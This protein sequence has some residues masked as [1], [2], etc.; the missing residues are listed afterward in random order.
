[1]PVLATIKIKN[2]TSNQFDNLIARLK[3]DGW[4]VTAKNMNEIILTKEEAD[5]SVSSSQELCRAT[6]NYFQKRVRPRTDQIFPFEHSSQ[7]LNKCTVYYGND[8]I[9][10]SIELYNLLPP[11]N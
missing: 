9:E 2:L 1:M 5:I 8:D 6:R 4:S 10:A 7:E 3:N 11:P